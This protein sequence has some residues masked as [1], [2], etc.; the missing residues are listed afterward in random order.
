[1]S[2][3]SQQYRSML[4]SPDPLDA[5]VVAI[6]QAPAQYSRRRSVKRSVGIATL[7]AMAMV[8]GGALNRWQRGDLNFETTIC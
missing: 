5:P 3:L 4:L 6:N 2:R 8:T 1:M 7:V